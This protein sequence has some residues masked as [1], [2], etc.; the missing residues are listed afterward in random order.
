MILCS[1][2][3]RVEIKKGICYEPCEEIEPYLRRENGNLRAKLAK[4]TETLREWVDGCD[5]YLKTHVDTGT[6]HRR[7]AYKDALRLLADATLAEI[8]AEC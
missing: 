8:T 4:A 6:I 7:S 2:C 3:R 5:I 1:K